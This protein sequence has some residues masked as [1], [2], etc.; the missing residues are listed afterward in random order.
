MLILYPAV[1]RRIKS[2]AFDVGRRWQTR[3]SQH[4]RLS[5]AQHEV[6]LSFPPVPT[7]E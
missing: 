4:N 5:A 6:R 3:P 2:A 1:I 7:V